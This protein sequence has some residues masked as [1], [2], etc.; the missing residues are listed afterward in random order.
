MNTADN[1]TVPVQGELDFGPE[2]NELDQAS[3]NDKVRFVYNDDFMR[4]PLVD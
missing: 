4:I 2:L 1:Q 3:Q